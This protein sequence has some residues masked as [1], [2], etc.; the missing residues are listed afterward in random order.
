MTC[1]TVITCVF[2]GGSRPSDKGGGEGKSSRPWAL[3]LIGSQFGP[4]KRG[5][6]GGDPGPSSGSTTAIWL[7]WVRC[8]VRGSRLG[9]PRSVLATEFFFPLAFRRLQWN[10]NT[11]ARKNKWK[12]KLNRPFVFK[13][14]IKVKIRKIRFVLVECWQRNIFFTCTLCTCSVVVLL[15]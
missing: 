8:Q 4:K 15:I 11:R 10:S 12:K 13:C 1:Y 9:G 14:S 3:R 5:V 2:S 6:G 7:L